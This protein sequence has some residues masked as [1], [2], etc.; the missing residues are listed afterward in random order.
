MAT[1]DVTRPLPDAV[2][3]YIEEYRVAQ[4]ELTQA[5][6]PAPQAAGDET[7][8]TERSADSLGDLSEPLEDTGGAGGTTVSGDAAH[9]G[10]VE[11]E[12]PRPRHPSLPP[13]QAVSGRELYDSVLAERGLPQR[14]PSERRPSDRRRARAGG[15]ARAGAGF[16]ARFGAERWGRDRW[17]RRS[18]MAPAMVAAAVVVA[19]GAAT[20]SAL[21]LAGVV[22]LGGKNADSTQA[23]AGAAG[24]SG[25]TAY[26]STGSPPPN[27]S[28]PPPTRDGPPPQ[29]PPPGGGPLP[30]PPPGAVTVSDGVRLGVRPPFGDPRTTYV[31]NGD[32]W[33]QGQTVTVAF[34]DAAVPPVKTVV[35]GSGTFSVALDQGAG[36]IVLPDG[37]YHVRASSGNRSEAVSFVV[38]PPLNP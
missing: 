32:G 31:L 17:R 23:A 15:G 11:G 25:Q 29:G 2:L 18:P 3:E 33:P 7:H 30:S 36:S 20:L 12:D 8:V 16:G 24:T 13:G 1:A 6:R 22:T 28:S 37:R 14:A 27:A 34:L 10:A 19:V 9:G 38:G 21:F 35:D 26:R 4:L 5:R